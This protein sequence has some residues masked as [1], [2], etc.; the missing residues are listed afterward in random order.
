M[1]EELLDG[2]TD[3]SDQESKSNATNPDPKSALLTTT[4]VTMETINEG[5]SSLDDDEGLESIKLPG[6]KAGV[7]K[8][9]AKT[10][11]KLGISYI[12][13]RCNL[14]YMINCRPLCLTRY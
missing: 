1:I 10:I 6:K 11:P 2:S 13:E 4:T 9:S 8:I 3:I 5:Q 14:D 7:Y 12:F